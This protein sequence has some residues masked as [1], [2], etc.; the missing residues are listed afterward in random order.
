[1]N[2]RFQ[3]F[4]RDFIMQASWHDQTHR[5]RQRDAGIIPVSIDSAFVRAGRRV[6]EDAVDN[7]A[8]PTGCGRDEII[9]KPSA[10]MVCTNNSELR[11][12]RHS[13]R[14]KFNRRII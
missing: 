3:K 5:I 12:Y 13:G 11:V 14:G 2:S 7:R 4:A 10:R 1:M 9:G 6:V 8:L